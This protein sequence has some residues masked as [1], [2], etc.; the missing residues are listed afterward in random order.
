MSSPAPADGAR[1]SG[2]GEG[3]PRRGAAWPRIARVTASAVLVV[4]AAVLVPVALIAVWV[5]DIVLDTDRYVA[6]VAPLARNRAV[7]DAAVARMADAV[8]VRVDGPRAAAELAAWLRSQGLPP[9]AARAVQSLGPQLDAAVNTTVQ[10]AATRI[11]RSEGFALAWQEANRTAHAA[12]VHV[13]TGEGR[14]AVGVEDGTVVLDIGTAV[15]GLKKEL[16]A[17]GVAPAA[18]IPATDERLVLLSSDQLGKVRK[19]ARALDVVGNWLPPL[20]AVTG[21]AGVLLA[22]HRRRTL[23]RAALGAAAGCLVVAVLLA[24]ARGYYLDHLPSA[25]RSRDAA[26]AVFDT[27]VRFLR[28][29]LRTAIVLGVVVAL[30]AWLA[31]PGRLPVAV[32][33][34][35]ERTAD[36]VARRGGDHGIGAGEAGAWTLTHRGSLTLAAVLA[37]AAGFAVWNQPTALVILFLLLVLLAVLALIALLAA[38]GR[39]AGAAHGGSGRRGQPD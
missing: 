39:R 6:T 37:V 16:T 21:A 15:D 17:R 20:V 23:A 34:G 14:G 18:A 35:C 1:P 11:V 31:G 28:L 5:H 29:A 3:P 27:L 26:A 33:D 25:V 13:L 2:G 36:D 10:K 32:R 9:Q 24:V 38:F 30:G 4:L 7:Q 22:R 12:V 19:A 8:S